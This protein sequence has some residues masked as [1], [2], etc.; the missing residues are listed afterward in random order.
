MEQYCD[1]RPLRTA[2]SRYFYA[3]SDTE[4]LIDPRIPNVMESA[5]RRGQAQPRDCLREIN[6]TP[7]QG[8]AL[9][10]TLEYK[11]GRG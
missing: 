10:Y 8:L 2:V 7:L 11:R 4:L 3:D 5:T 9:K 1:Q 6:D